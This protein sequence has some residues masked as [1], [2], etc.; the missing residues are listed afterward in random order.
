MKPGSVL[1]VARAFAISFGVWF[2]LSLIT[3]LQ[4]RVIDRTW[5]GQATPLDALKL[6]AARGFAY[7]LMTPPVFWLVRWFAARAKSFW[8]TLGLYVLGFA[9]FA[10]L[11]TVIRWI[12]LPP[13]NMIEQRFMPRS[14]VSVLHSL[15]NSFADQITMYI[16]I[17]ASAH[18][19]EYF[20][21]VRMQEVE[22]CEIQQALIASE[23]QILKMQLHPHFLFNTLHG[24]STLIDSD[25]RT[26]KAMVVKL[27]NLLRIALDYGSS[28]LIP[29]ADELGL[30][31]EY[32]DLEQMRCGD[33]LKVTLSIDP[34]T[35][36]MLLP[37]L[38][39]QPL[40]ENVIRHGVA[41]SRK[42]GWV[43]IISR[44][45]NSHLEICI[46][47][48]ARSGTPEGRGIGLRNTR[49]RLKHLY[50]DEAHF[51]FSIGSDQIAA[52]I[53]ILPVFVSPQLSESPASVSEHLHPEV[54]HASAAHR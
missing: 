54:D 4:Y 43:E 30:V 34:L 14:T 23:L 52:A 53:L 36:S 26:A 8:L 1:Q 11:L 50:D 39:L 13:W 10:I 37:Q 19:Y 48:N 33:R 51:S 20:K 18:A 27:S 46:Y 45:T 6:A 3:A 42:G 35:R 16:A 5:P 41:S 24:I 49:T 32:L 17:L 7:A 2:C 44:R 31:A 21:R 29:L 9:P 25:H 40:V 15:Q 22:K 28:D 38:I 12:L 47:N